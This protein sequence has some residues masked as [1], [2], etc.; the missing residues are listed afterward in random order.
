MCT[1]VLLRRPD[2]DWPVLIAA[3]RDELLSRPWLP[4]ARHWP[5]RADVTAGLDELAGG[6]WL[7]VNGFGVVAGIL[8][9]EGTLGPKDGFRSRGELPMEALDHADARAAATALGHLDPT[10]YRPFN[11]II[12][13]NQDA[14][15]LAHAEG[16]GRVLV[17][18]LP[19]GISMITSRERNDLHV[20]RIRD[21]L[22]RFEQ[23]AIPDPDIEDWTAWREL[24]ASREH[25]LE[26][27]P[28]GAMNFVGDSGFGTA[29]ASL[30]ALPAISR[31]GQ[32]AIWLFAAGR[33]DE[34]PFVSVDLTTAAV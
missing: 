31:V 17:T 12:A 33:P 24:L 11:M 32:S 34:Q 25:D 10:A 22:P 7:G 4:P 15:W 30:I 14:F 19:T 8:N 27:G 13:D 20:P 9:R 29:S 21:Y 3:N 6:T 28:R 18:E 16:V 2:H 5:D 26:E 1:L 23:A